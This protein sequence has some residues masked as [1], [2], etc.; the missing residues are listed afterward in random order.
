MAFNRIVDRRFDAENPRT[1]SRHLPAG[2]IS[3]VSAWGL[4]GLAG[5]GLVGSAGLGY[6]KDRFASDA[7][8]QSNPGAYAEYK[9]DEAKGWFFLE[10]VQG[11][12]GKKLGAVP[13]REVSDGP[14]LECS[15]RGE[16]VDLTRFPAPLWHSST[17]GRCTVRARGSRVSRLA[18]WGATAR[19]SMH[20]AG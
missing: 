3:L 5:A 11:I 9:V 18:R 20:W 8:Q 2:Q 17:A 10:K 7:L 15:Q 13:P 16:S 1:A 19:R 4:C 12:D 14:V 6:A